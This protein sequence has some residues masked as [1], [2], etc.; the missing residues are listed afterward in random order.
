MPKDPKTG[1]EWILTCIDA[2]TKYAW[3]FSLKTKES[4]PIVGESFNFFQ[5]I[6]SLHCFIISLLSVCLLDCLKSIIQR[7][8]SAAKFHS[9]NGSE[10]TLELHDQ[11]IP[12]DLIFTLQFSFNLNCSH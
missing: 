3:C 1:S 8:G 9:D 11:V 12:I 4:A 2:F 7:E 6:I 10:F 5:R